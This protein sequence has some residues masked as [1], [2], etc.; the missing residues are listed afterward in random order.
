M[1]PVPRVSIVIPTFD[2]QETVAAAVESCL[3]QTFFDVEIICVDDASTDETARIL[4]Q[5]AERDPRIRLIPQQQNRSAFQARRAGIVAAT[6][7]YILFVDGD[8][9]LNPHAAEIS[10]AAAQRHD[11]DLVGFGVEVINTESHVVGGYQTRL[12]PKHQDLRGPEILSNL[13]PVDQPAQGQL[14]RYL[15]RTQLLRE[16]YAL[17]PEDVVLPR[18]ND[19]PVMYLAAALA[20]RYVSVPNRLYRYHFGRGGSGRVVDTIERAQFYAKAIDSIDSVRPAV[21]TIARTSIDPTSLLNNFESVRLSIIGYVCAYLLKHTRSDLQEAVLNDLHARVPPADVVVA[22]VRFYPECLPALKAHTTQIRLRDR[23]VQ[24]VLLTTRTVTTGGVSAVLLAQARYLMQA[25]FRV[26]IVARRYGSD[27]GAVP[28]GA[29]FVEMVG[30]GLPERLVEWAGICRKHD[31]DVIVDH[32]VLYSRDWPEYALV[33]RSLGVASIGWLHNF[34]GRP[35]YDLNGLHELLK[36]N[37]PL[38]E[39]LVTLSPLDVAFWKLRGVQ[40]SVYVPNP[41]SPMLLESASKSRP[42]QLSGRRVELMWWGRLDEHT[43]QVSQLIEVAD[44]L[45]KLSVDFHLTVIGPDWADWSAARFNTIVRKRR[46]DGLVEAVGEMR[47]Q[48]LIDAIDSADAFVSTS[49]I[50]GYQLTIAEAQVRGLPV[51]MYELP[52]LTLVQR[53]D[54]IVTAPQGDAATL[55]LRIAA[56]FTSPER[57]TDLSRASLAAAARELSHDFGRLYEQVVTD[58]LPPSSLRNRH[59]P[60]PNSS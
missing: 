3:A 46:L 25:G 57:Y 47:G 41:P 22:A 31:V 48:Q 54:G 18:V 6:G 42:K 19:L 15:F 33:A 28:P 11:A 17:L 7:E 37:A 43:K 5:M 36:A 27:P 44:Q 1:S 10:I 13:F 51:F 9:E 49:I 35:I 30:H 8:D 45:R 24:S 58:T 38:L 21:Q 23:P 2:D 40:H 39:T 16:V 12:A 60:M 34:A 55:A 4:E 32:Q 59:S 20:S 29:S 50:E 56:V 26:T 14:W 53:N 52:W